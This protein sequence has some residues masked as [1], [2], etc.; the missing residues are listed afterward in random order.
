MQVFN[1]SLKFK[2]FLISKLPMAWIAG[3]K[4]LELTSDKAVV[5]VRYGYWTQNPF[6]SMYFAVMAMA[7]ELSTG[8]LVLSQVYKSGKNISTL[9]YKMQADFNKKAIGKIRFICDDGPLLQGIIQKAIDTGEG[10]TLEMT[11][12]GYNE[13][14]EQVAKFVITWSMKV[15]SKS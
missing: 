4:K 2:L 11:S 12:I 15:K 6:K 8:L 5:G 10:Q 9:V 1:S 3:L 7:A 14:N 13:N